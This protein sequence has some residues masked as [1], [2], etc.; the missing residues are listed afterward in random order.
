MNQF[1]I[2]IDE[3]YLELVP[4]LNKE[5]RQLLKESIMLYGQRE[6]IIINENG[7]ILDGHT[8]YEICKE[9]GIEPKFKT[10]QF[11]NTDQEREYVIDAN[12]SRRHLT[13]FQKFELVYSLYLGMKRRDVNKW[14]EG[15]RINREL[16]TAKIFARQLGM[17][18]DYFFKCQYLKTHA[19]PEI[20]DRLRTGQSSI[21]VEHERIKRSEPQKPH[22]RTPSISQL[23]TF[24]KN[25][26]VIL[27][28]INSILKKYWELANC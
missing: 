1:Q 28:E 5:E 10:R 23:K 6:E 11:N 8:R 7:K 24:F 20:I 21:Q 22:V 15:K 26:P 18:R 13:L 17:S 4:R 14:L 25:E 27:E 9:L 19:P 16:D 2:T 12:L 3:N